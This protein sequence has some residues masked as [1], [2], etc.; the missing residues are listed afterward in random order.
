MAARRR[1]LVINQYYW[2]GVEATAHLLSE[3][4]EALVEDFDV[5]VI[6]GRLRHRPDLPH[7][8]VH[9]GVRILRVESTAYD[10]AF[11]FRRGLNYLT[12]L[13]GG[14]RAALTAP[15][16]DVVLCGTDPPIAGNLGLLIGLRHR[17]PLVVISEDVFPE[18]AVALH[19][20]RNPL[21]V[22]GLKLLV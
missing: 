15:R 2:P 9:K 8:Q 10:R 21:V 18:I 14:L 7:E 3:L 5:T 6:T 13:F 20:L 17:A 19:R 4:C 12:Y 1:L 11:L 22:G 16:A